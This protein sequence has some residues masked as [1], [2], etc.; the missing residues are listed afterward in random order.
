MSLS[1]QALSRGL[2][3]GL[4]NRGRDLSLRLLVIDMAGLRTLTRPGPRM[5][6]LNL[7]IDYFSERVAY[8]I[9]YWPNL[10]TRLLLLALT[11]G[12]SG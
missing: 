8:T 2:K 12:L 4:Q 1:L 5:E 9:P 7:S 3:K 11:A 6:G 10:N